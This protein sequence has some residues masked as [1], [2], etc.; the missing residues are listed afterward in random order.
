MQSRTRD[1]LC[2][3]KHYLW[4]GSK[5]YKFCDRPNFSA[6]DFKDLIVLLWT[7]S[8][9]LAK[10]KNMKTVSTKYKRVRN[11]LKY[12]SKNVKC[13]GLLFHI[14]MYINYMECIH[15][16]SCFLFFRARFS[17]LYKSYWDIRV[18]WLW[19]PAFLLGAVDFNPESSSRYNYVFWWNDILIIYC[20]YIFCCFFLFPVVSCYNR[21]MAITKTLEHKK[22]YEDE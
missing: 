20:W 16:C 17:V 11:C 9:F 12:S 22:L 15:M 13:H 8:N 2:H 7:G 5:S 1:C 21:R 19:I 3:H 4:K 6:T 10:S 18:T 14:H